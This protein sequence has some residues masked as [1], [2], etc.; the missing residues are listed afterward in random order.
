MAFAS[1]VAKNKA[2]QAGITT[3]VTNSAA[4]GRI[5][6]ANAN[7]VAKARKNVRLCGLAIRRVNRQ[8]IITTSAPEQIHSAADQD[9][10]VFG[11]RIISSVQCPL[12]PELSDAGGPQRSN[13]QATCSARIRSS[14]FV[15]LSAC[16]HTLSRVNTTGSESGATWV[17]SSAT[18][19]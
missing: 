9:R 19:S 1:R 16:N 14:D 13:L 15:R 8:A 2:Y 3:P 10:R 17:P 12:T 11:V 4:T 18:P 5:V 7:A 6:G